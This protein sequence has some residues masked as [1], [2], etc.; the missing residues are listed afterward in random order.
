MDC[1]QD[2]QVGSCVEDG[3]GRVL[4]TGGHSFLHNH[5]GKMSLLVASTMTGSIEYFQSNKVISGVPECN[6]VYAP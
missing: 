6:Y 2:I 5:C 1:H 3:D 4:C